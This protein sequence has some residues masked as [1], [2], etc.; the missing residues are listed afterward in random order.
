[1]GI[2]LWL[3]GVLMIGLYI[4][5]V[6][7][8]CGVTESLSAS[9]YVLAHPRWFSVCVCA[10]AALEGM[11]LWTS[12]AYAYEMLAGSVMCMGLFGVGLVPQFRGVDKT[13]HEILAVV[14]G[15]ACVALAC[16]ISP[17]LL[18]LPTLV[19]GLGT[20]DDGDKWMWWLEV[21]GIFLGAVCIGM[22]VV[23]W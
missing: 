11:A 2:V 3:G 18:I 15:G 1:M 17:Y 10:A 21:A 23:L 9:W 14:S 19:F 20:T 4:L 8:R 5:C 6:C 16:L 7:L 13:A 22:E 12:G